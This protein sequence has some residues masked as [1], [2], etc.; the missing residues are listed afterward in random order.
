M[1][2]EG[3]RHVYDIYIIKRRRRDEKKEERRG[4]GSDEEE[5]VLIY[6]RTKFGRGREKD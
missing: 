5:C 2:T 6:C 3:E 1:E 4:S